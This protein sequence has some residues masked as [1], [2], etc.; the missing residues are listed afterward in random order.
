MPNGRRSELDLL[1]SCLRPSAT[2]QPVSGSDFPTARKSASE[3]DG[4][5]LVRSTYRRDHNRLVEPV[6]CP[7]E[8]PVRKI[9]AGSS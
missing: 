8:Y 3:D 6:A 5:L 9:V 1:Q 4:V 7:L 2:R